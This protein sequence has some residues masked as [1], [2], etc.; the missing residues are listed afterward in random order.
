MPRT[1]TFTA[2][3]RGKTERLEE[4]EWLQNKEK[5]IQAG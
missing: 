5:M 2:R 3:D 4:G 1:H